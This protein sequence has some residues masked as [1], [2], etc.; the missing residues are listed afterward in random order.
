MNDSNP[1]SELVHYDIKQKF[2]SLL[3]YSTEL[4]KQYDDLLLKI[5][6]EVEDSSPIHELIEVHS[7]KIE[8]KK[9]CITSMNHTFRRFYKI[10]GV[11]KYRL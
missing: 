3:Y 1:K 7:S 4:I 9:R 8:A 10:Y 5:K 11:K 2:N 6:D